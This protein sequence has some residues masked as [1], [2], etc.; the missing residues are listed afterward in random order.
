[1]NLFQV[2]ALL[3]LMVLIVITVA[4]TIRGRAT[5]REGFAWVLVWLAAGVAIA[6]PNV[7]TKVA[8]LLGIR[9]GADLVLYCAVVVMMVGF[10]MVFVRLRR[11]Q[12]ELTLI[13]RH[14]AIHDA[15]DTSSLEKKDCP[16]EATGS[17]DNAS[18][19]QGSREGK[20]IHG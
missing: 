6:W 12:R 8:H 7:T 3:V 17:S 9:R 13:V 20:D 4:S 19:S 1:M 16:T 15:T 18:P 5:R 10:L 14:L 2:I 11:L